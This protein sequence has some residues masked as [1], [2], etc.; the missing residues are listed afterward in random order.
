MGSQPAQQRRQ[1]GPVVAFV[2]VA[3]AV[4]GGLSRRAGRVRRFLVGRGEPGVQVKRCK[5]CVHC[6]RNVRFAVIADHQAAGRVELLFVQQRRKKFPVRLAA[7]VVR[8]KVD[9]VELLP[10]PQIP[11]LVGRE[12][13]LRVTQQPETKAL[14][15]QRSQRFQNMRVEPQMFH[16]RNAEQLRRI[17]PQ[18]LGADALFPEQRIHHLL[19]RDIRE[20]LVALPG[21]RLAGGHFPF[22]GPLQLCARVAGT[23]KAKVEGRLFPDLRTFLRVD[24]HQRAVQVKDQVGIGHRTA[25]HLPRCQMS[26]SYSAMV[27]SEENMPALAMF[28]RHLRRQPIGSQA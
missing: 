14:C 24:V 9:A 5:A 22:K 12:D 26:R 18:S 20:A 13:P 19:E 10:Q 3:A 16:G 11:Q 28:T 6:A 2:F 27:R 7:V 23:V 4:G 25:H 21:L 15:P 8:G 1:G 17:L